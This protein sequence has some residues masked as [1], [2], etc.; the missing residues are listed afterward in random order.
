MVNI[1]TSVVISDPAYEPGSLCSR[2]INNMVPGEYICSMQTLDSGLFGARVSGIKLTLKGWVKKKAASKEMVY[3][4]AA[5]H[6]MCGFYAREYFLGK[7]REGQESTEWRN[8]YRTVEAVTFSHETGF[9]SGVIDG[10]CFVSSTGYGNGVYNCAVKKDG[11][12][13]VFELWLRY[14]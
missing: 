2:T 9:G 3:E 1:G 14:I 10:K 13:Q 7:N 11:L 6:A 4:I 5:D 12:G 8:W